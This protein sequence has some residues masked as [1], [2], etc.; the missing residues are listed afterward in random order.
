MVKG[1]FSHDRSVLRVDND[2]LIAVLVPL[3]LA[4]GPERF[5]AR[6]QKDDIEDEDRCD[7]GSPTDCDDIPQKGRKGSVVVGANEARR[8]VK[9][10][11]GQ[12]G[13]K[14]GEAM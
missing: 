2:F 9:I 7:V 4:L 12:H 10:D 11:S 6:R 3:H 8:E 5:V 13:G 14:I 1:W